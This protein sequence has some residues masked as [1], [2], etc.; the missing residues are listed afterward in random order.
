MDK[1]FNSAFDFFAYAIPGT[2]L[3]CSF[4]I[5]DSS[6]CEPFDLLGVARK[7]DSGMAVALVVV[8]YAVGFA[9]N[10]IG[11]FV[12]R[13]IGR[14]LWAERFQ[15]QDLDTPL[16]ISEKYALIRELAPANFKYIET[17][18]VFC[19][20]AHNLALA[21]LFLAGQSLLKV[22]MLRGENIT[23]W[24]IMAV[25]SLV[26]F[27]LLIHR[28]VVFSRWAADD[29]IATIKILRLRDKAQA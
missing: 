11:R 21:F 14:Q 19:S 28:A 24:L 15:F 20:T 12:Y 3:V 29:I 17:W 26:L 1:I 6:V 16:T 25:F 4:F 9:H 7:I 10:N 5:W 27:F 22:L 18:N 2:F 13:R 8:G 23:S